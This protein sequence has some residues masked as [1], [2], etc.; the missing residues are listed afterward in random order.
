M[1]S[2]CRVTCG[3]LDVM[4]ERK[5]PDVPFESWVE[6]QIREAVER[7]EFDNLPGSG[8]PLPVSGDGEDWWLRGYLAR[9][10]VPTDALLPASLQLRKE[11]ELL[12]VT[13]RDLGTEE[14]VR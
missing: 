1:W 3:G 2:V 10:E 4:T 13:V 5:P 6:R 9:E 12:P 14:E 8:R 11:I 7:G